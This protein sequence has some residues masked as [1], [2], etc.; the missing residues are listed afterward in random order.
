MKKFGT[1]LKR[2]SVK[3]LLLGSGELGKEVA[4]EAMRL[5]IEVVAC[6]RYEAAPAMLVANS[7]YVF[8]MRDGAAMRY[9]VETVEPDFIV[10]D[11]TAAVKA[12]TNKSFPSSSPV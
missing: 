11:A 1:P 7:A 3:M 4:I 10:A 5:G 2:S 9:V 8:D 6:D 12:D